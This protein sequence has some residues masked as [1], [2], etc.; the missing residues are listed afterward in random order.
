MI[1]LGGAAIAITGIVL[2]ASDLGYDKLD[3]MCNFNNN[4]WGNDRYNTPRPSSETRD[5][6]LERCLEAKHIAVVRILS[7]TIYFEL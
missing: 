1:N 6:Y 5:Q 4:Y 7:N 2:Y 3:W